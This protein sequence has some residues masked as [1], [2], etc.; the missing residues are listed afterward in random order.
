MFSLVGKAVPKD[1]VVRRARPVIGSA[2]PWKTDI[3]INDPGDFDSQS[4]SGDLGRERA[5]IECKYLSPDVSAGSY[6]TNLARA[7]T[8][9]NDIRLENKAKLFLVVNRMPE[10]GEDPRDTRKLFETIGVTFVNFG[11]ESHRRR[12]VEEIESLHSP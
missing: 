12:L 4:N 7:Y 5:V 11:D 10:K 1:L 3:A 2:G 8:S 9:L 6:P